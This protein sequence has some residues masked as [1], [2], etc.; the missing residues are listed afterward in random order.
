MKFVSYSF[1]LLTSLT[2]FAP[3]LAKSVK[4]GHEEVVKFVQATAAPKGNGS[5]KHPFASLAAAALAPWDILIVLPSTM[6]LDG[7]ITLKSGQKIIG[8]CDPTDISVSPAQPI[9]TNLNGTLNNGVGVIATGNNVIKNIYFQNTYS[10]SI[11][12]DNATN[13][14]I[15]DC[16]ITGHNQGNV[17][18]TH[19]HFAGNLVGGI[20]GQCSQSGETLIDHVIIRSNT[21]G[22]GIQDLPVSPAHRQ[23]TVCNCELAQLNDRGIISAPLG[24]S[25]STAVSDVVVKDS[26]LH[27]FISSTTGVGFGCNPLNGSLQTVLIKNSVF[28]NIS[29]FNIEGVPFHDIS[30]SGP[31]PEL[32]IE[33][34]SCLF[35]NSTSIAIQIINDN[36][37][38][39][40][41]LATNSTSNNV[42]AFFGSLI[43]DN[44][45][46]RNRLCG[47]TV[48]GG[49]FYLAETD[50]N[51]EQPSQ[52]MPVEITELI[53]N[54][55]SGSFGIVLDPKIPWT[56]LLDITAE[57]NCFYGTGTSSIC[58]A[59]DTLN[60]QASA[61]PLNGFINAHEN[62]FS[63]FTADIED[64]GSSI[65]YLL[66]K[67][68]WGQP[69][70]SCA[71]T[72]PCL[73]YQTCEKGACLG[74]IVI[75]PTT[76]P[77]FAGYIDASHPLAASIACP[78]N[79]CFSTSGTSNPS[80][81]LQ[82][83]LSPEGRHQ[84][85]ERIQKSIRSISPE[86][87][88]AAVV[89]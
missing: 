64:S 73:P 42:A 63:G 54:C 50:T 78:R 13:L 47:N 37:A 24:S 40:E 28:N 34:D 14:T 31:S 7:G 2:I 88:E 33:I 43:L 23:L 5:E 60:L 25:T 44:G 4:H 32:K 20:Q 45:V 9:I 51:Q 27:D 18:L 72:S 12:Y 86:P 39:S 30:I 69:T 55:F 85:L 41:A 21:A 67:N 26:H 79:C 49:V 22:P 3:A 6:A 70:T 71:A 83:R 10:S 61:S 29:F 68:F 76:P 75:L 62:T 77:L 84:K 35:E 8:A 59:T 17:T 11:N 56:P 16:L 15:Q 46:Q 82:A 89:S 66:S 38:K 80:P 48:T 74:P 58:F 57:C 1:V 36:V 19:G 53:G 52:A 81:T 87:T 65:S